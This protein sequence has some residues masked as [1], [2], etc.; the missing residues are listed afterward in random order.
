MGV[1]SDEQALNLSE[2]LLGNDKNIKEFLESKINE[3]TGKTIDEDTL[4]EILKPYAKTDDISLDITPESITDKELASNSVTTEKII[5]NSITI[6]KFSEELQKIINNIGNS[7]KS[8]TTGASKGSVSV[9]GND[10]LVNGLGTAA[11]KTE[12][13]F[14]PAGAVQAVKDMVVSEKEERSSEISV[15]RARIDLLSTLKEGSTTGDAELA[16]IRVGADG[17]I[18]PSAGNAMRIQVGNLMDSVQEMYNSSTINTWVNKG[19]SANGA[20]SSS[21]NLTR[22]TN[23]SL[24]SANDYLGIKMLGDYEV[25]I[26]AWENNTFKGRWNGT[27]FATDG[28]STY[29][30]NFNFTN[31][32]NFSFRFLVRN[33]KDTSSTIDPSEGGNC[34]LL[35][36]KI[37]SLSANL[38]NV[39]DQLYSTMSNT[40][41]WESGSF[42]SKGGVV[43]N[44]SRLRTKKYLPSNIISVSCSDGYEFLVYA[45]DSADNYV[46]SI[47]ASGYKTSFDFASYPDYKF[48]MLL[49]NSVNN[50]ANI[51]P[52]ESD[53]VF[54]KSSLIKELNEELNYYG[55]I[56]DGVTDDSTAIQKLVDE[57]ASVTIPSDKNIFLSKSIKI[58]TAN[59]KI[60]NGNGSTFIV[61]GDFPAFV[62]TGTVGASAAPGK[63]S[64]KEANT[65]IK[66]CKITS[67]NSN[68]GTGIKLNQAFKT[69]IENCMIH[70]LSNGIIIDGINRDLIICNNNIYACHDYGIWYTNTCN[71][72]QMNLTG[73]IISY[74][75]RCIFYDS[76]VQIANNQIVGNDIE[77][78][79][80]PT[81]STDSM[82]IEITSNDE[83]AGQLSEIVISGNTIQGHTVSSHIIK[84]TGGNSRYI[85]DLI[86]SNNHISNCSTS[87]ITANKIRGCL[88]NSNQAK[89][90]GNNFIELSN[91]LGVSVVGNLVRKNAGGSLI[92]A[93][94]NISLITENNNI[95]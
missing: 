26:Y 68:V 51:T 40:S 31:Y 88:I 22:L 95:I 15:E 6:E 5:D 47:G 76:P 10:V 55:I 32:P 83:Y 17:I 41:I 45:W 44:A 34:T 65:I 71:T 35:T 33:S 23:S 7:V 13:D 42:N 27:A 12:S 16:D 1:L 38:S 14:E 37:N 87:A 81:D 50:S 70:Y 54:F 3:L 2:M 18:Y 62:V 28:T 67:S 92:N 74:C 63:T 91:S 11:Y 46:G 85:D 89:S 80:Y 61:G 58:D 73:N 20:V 24:V 25:L 82:C 29:V 72:H 39:T 19:V 57:N 66:N 36:S 84:I 56:G 90:I 52:S 94:N 43:E 64:V 75:K 8:I 60:F 93:I 48:K 69:I 86:I 9:D 4:K 78:A 77:I 53:S 79:N 49:R 59:L 21:E 30:K